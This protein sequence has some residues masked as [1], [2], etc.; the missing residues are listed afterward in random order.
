MSAPSLPPP[1]PAR[2]LRPA[3]LFCGAVIVAAILA[4]YSRSFGGR[5]L[6]DDIESIA[7]NATIRHLSTA[8]RPPDGATVSGRPVLNLSFALNYA[9]SGQRVWSYH[10][11]NVAIHAASSLLLLGIVR[12]TLATRAAGSRAAPESLAIAFAVALLWALHPLQSESVAYVVQRAESLMG[13]FY[14]LTLYAFIRGAEGGPPAR[15][16]RIAAFAACLLGMATKE[17]MATA[18]LVVLLYDRAFVGG[19]FGEAWRR[20]KALYVALASCWLPMA[21]FAWLGGG[22]SG[23]AGFGSGVAWWA[24]SLTQFRA[25]ALYVRLS[26]WPHPL[27]AD[28]GR[29]LGGSRL[30][31]AV[32]VLLVVSLAAGTVVQLR[33]NRPVGFLGAWFL[34]ILAPSSSVIPVST[35]IIAEHRMY[36]PLAAILTLAAAALYPAV[37][38]RRPFLALAGALALVLGAMTFRRAAVYQDAAAFWTDD[39]QKVPGN[40]GAWNNLGVILA[41]NGDQA[42][43]IAHYRRALEL[44]P[45]FAFAHFNLGNSLAATG[46]AGE[47]AAEY[48]E[49]LKF[50]PRD[51]A[52]HRRLAYALALGKRGYAAAAEYREALRLEP[53]SA[54]AWAGLGAAMVQVGNLAEAA[55]AYSHAV[56]LRP[57]RAGTRVDYGD[58]LAQLGRVPEGIREYREALR[59][60]PGA[61]D[62]HNNL[63]GLLAEGGRLAEARAEFEEA[64]RLRPGYAEARDNLER[65]RRMEGRAGMS[66]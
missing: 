66:R 51:P 29:F 8:L 58:V 6:Y 64:L 4:A 32:G 56:L 21:Y 47:A 3:L 57:D 10:A 16:W 18:P 49:A 45:A 48:E 62:V 50:R 43:A 61:A 44:V 54:E 11:L 25:V 35:E 42:A 17:V 13:L 53:G 1:A 63:G 20:R 2:E 34:L 33:R 38:R 59:I 30:E 52:I 24:Y 14:L 27:I 39:V 41:E 12:R 65:V 60:E 36:L 15:P 28:Y 23:T 9:L 46:R 19:S 22:R 7:E 31:I 26:L 37:G 5:F 40:A 55:D